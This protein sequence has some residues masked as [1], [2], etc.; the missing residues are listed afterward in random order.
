MNG[1]LPNQPHVILNLP[2]LPLNLTYVILS[3][4]HLLKTYPISKSTY[5]TYLTLSPIEPAPHLRGV[6]L[7]K[8][9]SQPGI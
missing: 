3:L 6:H 5:F 1:T 2:Y 9:T 4:P 7:G 8:I